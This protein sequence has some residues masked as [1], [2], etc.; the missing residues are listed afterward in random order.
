[1]IEDY[2]FLKVEYCLEDP[3]DELWITIKDLKFDKEL[4]GWRF[5]QNYRTSSYIIFF[6]NEIMISKINED[7]THTCMYIQKGKEVHINLFNEFKRLIQ[8]YY[9]EIKNRRG[10]NY[11]K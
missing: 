2:D 6:E 10:G 11:L 7:G 8:Y 9:P 4:E 1:M 5:P 3:E